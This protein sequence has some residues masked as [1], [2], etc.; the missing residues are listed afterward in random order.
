MM[1]KKEMNHTQKTGEGGEREGGNCICKEKEKKGGEVYFRKKKK[2][3]RR[4]REEKKK[5]GREG[6]LYM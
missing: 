2:E 6:E 5:T 3:T 1:M 4:R